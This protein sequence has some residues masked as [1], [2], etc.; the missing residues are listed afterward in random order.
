MKRTRSSRRGLN[1]I[2]DFLKSA[3]EAVGGLGGVSAVEVGGAQVLPSVPLR[4]M[5]Q[6]AVSM[7]AATP[8]MAFLAPRRARRRWNWA[9]R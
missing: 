2:A 5:C 6:A 7:E 9:C 4:S 3:D 8:M 1:G